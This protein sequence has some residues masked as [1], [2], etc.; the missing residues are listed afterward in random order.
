MWIPDFGMNGP[1]PAHESVC[2]IEQSRKGMGYGLAGFTIRRRPLE[3][4][5]ENGALSRNG[6][7]GMK[8]RVAASCITVV[9]S[10]FRV[11]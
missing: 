3:G 2:S 8:S 10:F 7:G 9:N 1:L 4:R 6:M 5:Y 11:E